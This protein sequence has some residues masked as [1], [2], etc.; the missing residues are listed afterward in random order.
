MI[1]MG[2]EKQGRPYVKMYM[3]ERVRSNRGLAVVAIIMLT[4]FLTLAFYP[5]GDGIAESACVT[6]LDQKAAW[7]VEYSKAHGE[8]PYE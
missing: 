2:N 5:V 8:Y 4:V 1:V 6:Q 7:A 3:D